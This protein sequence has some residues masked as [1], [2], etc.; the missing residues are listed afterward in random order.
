[1]IKFF[2]FL[3]FVNEFEPNVYIKFKLTRGAFFEND[4]I[5]IYTLKKMG[6]KLRKVYFL[7]IMGFLILGY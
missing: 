7:G 4:V 3:I 5:L 6:V 2:K 1:M